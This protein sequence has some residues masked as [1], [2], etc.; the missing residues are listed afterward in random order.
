MGI[1]RTRRINH[2]GSGWIDHSEE[3][4]M[5]IQVQGPGTVA[6]QGNWGGWRG[7]SLF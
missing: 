7:Q 5:S 1:M 6:F 4:W 2:R 3:T